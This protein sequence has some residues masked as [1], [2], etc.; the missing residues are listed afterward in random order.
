MANYK[1]TDFFE[2]VAKKLSCSEIEIFWITV[3]KNLASLLSEVWGAENVLYIN[4]CQAMQA[5]I[6]DFKLNEIIQSDRALRLDYNHAKKYLERIQKPIADFIEENKIKFVIG[7]LTWG[8]E[9]LTYRLIKKLDHLNCIYLNPHTIRIPNNYFGFFIDEQQSILL[10]A[11]SGYQITI[12]LIPKK[13]DYLQLNEIL[14][15]KHF[16][17]TSRAKRIISFIS[18]KNYDRND[19]TIIHS[20]L[21]NLFFKFSIE[22]NR[23]LYRFAKK[24][25]PKVNAKYAL[26]L[27]HKQPEASIDVIGRYYEDQYINI[28]NIWRSLPQNHILIIKEH[29]NAIGDR[30]IFFY[31]KIIKLPNVQLIDESADTYNLI[32]SAEFIITVTGTAAYE[33]ALMNIKSYTYAP[34]FFNKLSHCN[35]LTLESFTKIEDLS[36]PPNNKIQNNTFE[37]SNWLRKRIFKGIISDPISNPACM[38]KINIENVATAVELIIN[39]PCTMDY[40]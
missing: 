20:R 22:I 35:R 34:T 7:E 26:Y 18:R 24:T 21:K 17:L 15:K 2:A 31:R 12:E 27:L 6:S 4:N 38:S 33:A 39:T 32:A 8:H 11:N 36:T 9:I 40:E 10:P 16:S 23:E 13:P 1:K 25:K 30:S 14:L 19:P 5:A 28:Y 29:S 3:N 37:F